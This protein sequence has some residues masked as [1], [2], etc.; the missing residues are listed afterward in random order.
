[1]SKINDSV[2]YSEKKELSRYDLYV[3]LFREFGIRVV[4]LVPL[5]NVFLLFTNKGKKIL[6]RVE[7]SKENLKF[8]YD[9]L[10]YVRKEFSN[11]VSFEQKSSGDIYT[12]WNGELYC[13][14]DLAQGRECEYSNPLDLD[15]AAKGIA[16]LHKASEGFRNGYVEKNMLG[17]AKE[18]FKRRYEELTFFK[19]F[20]FL[21]EIKN[22]FDKIFLEN[23]DIYLKQIEES[24]LLIDRVP[25]YKLCSEED[26]IAFCHHDLAHH[27]ILINNNE[28][29][30]I[31][32]D[33]A[34]IDLKVHD[35][36]NFVNKA[37]K[38]FAFDI[39]RF[40]NILQSYCSINTLDK[41][42]FEM[43]KV[44]LSFPEDFYSISKDYY[45]RRKEWE[46][47]TFIDRLKKKVEYK[48]D[49]EEFLN[50]LYQMQI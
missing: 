40:K 12:I 11:V 34:I 42:E 45:A 14:M 23:V 15:I 17:K 20:V 9:G 26:K 3:D 38:N 19:K 8:I 39:E 31:D 7:Y 6:K 36:C 37:I 32:F 5:R 4:D 18:N 46:E 2:K 21:H 22:E 16:K 25:Y 33:Y 13:I 30:F 10:E 35:I 43:L 29:Y 1:M 24:I 44:Y 28:A 49:R 47:D 41:R 50:N 27:N 48:D